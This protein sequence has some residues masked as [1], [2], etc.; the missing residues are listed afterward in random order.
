MNSRGQGTIEY[1]VIIAIVVVISLVVVALLLGIFDTNSGQ[2]GAQTQQ[3]DLTTQPLAVKS[4]LIGTGEDA[5][6]LIVISNN[7]GN[8]VEDII[9]TLGDSQH[10]YYNNRLSQ[11]DTKTLKLTDI[12]V[13]CNPGETKTYQE[14]KITYITREGIS[15]TIN[16]GTVALDC[17]AD[18][19]PTPTK[20]PTEEIPPFEIVEFRSSGLINVDT[21]ALEERGVVI[22]T[23]NN[24]PNSALLTNIIVDGVNI[25]WKRCVPDY[26]DM[27]KPSVQGSFEIVHSVLEKRPGCQESNIC[28]AKYKGLSQ[29]NPEPLFNPNETKVIVVRYGGLIGNPENGGINL[30][31]AEVGDNYSPEIILSYTYNGVD[32]NTKP[33]VKTSVIEEIEANDLYGYYELSEYSNFSF[34]SPVTF[35][36][37]EFMYTAINTTESESWYGYDSLSYDQIGIVVQNTSRFDVNIISVDINGTTV[38]RRTDGE[39]GGRYLPLVNLNGQYFST[40]PELINEHLVE[41]NQFTGFYFSTGDLLVF[42]DQSMSVGDRTTISVSI[43]Y[44]INGVLGTYNLGNIS[45]NIAS[46]GMYGYSYYLP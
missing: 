29:Y 40:N 13:V 45:T 15:Q 12:E 36:L 33:K 18:A 41:P 5:N 39:T 37:T 8:L 4:S 11:G 3:L 38:E 32:Y 9:V 21:G 23:K 31:N 19:N 24:L 16:Y 20:P 30:E 14:L 25:E 44:S 10:T 2:I 26:D 28:G 34:G 1:L 46:S 22:A 6:G 17:I 7:T 43:N 27:G 42:P 35:K